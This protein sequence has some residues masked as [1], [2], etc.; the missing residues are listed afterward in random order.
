MIKKVYLVSTQTGINALHIKHRILGR[1]LVSNSAG[2]PMNQISCD[3]VIILWWC[4]LNIYLFLDLT[5]IKFTSQV[6]NNPTWWS[7]SMKKN[8][9]FQKYLFQN[10]IDLEI[11]KNQMDLIIQN[12]YSCDDWEKIIGS[13][14]DLLVVSYARTALIL[15]QI[16]CKTQKRH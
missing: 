9:N 15:K 6:W 1:W 16:V 8:L 11:L 2:K 14:L 5:N 3:K 12:R 13:I 4:K 7:Y 10:L